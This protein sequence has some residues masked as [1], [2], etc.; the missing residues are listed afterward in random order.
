MFGILRSLNRLISYSLILGLS[1]KERKQSEREKQNDVKA[2]VQNG[3]H[4]YDAGRG[5]P[6]VVQPHPP[7]QRQR[8]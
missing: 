6:A 1:S 5:P 8:S 4:V 2:E 3:C 7:N